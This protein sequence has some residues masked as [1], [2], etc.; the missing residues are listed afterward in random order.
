MSHIHVL[1]TAYIINQL[2]SLLSNYQLL[3]T[4]Y[5]KASSFMVKKTLLHSL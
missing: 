4:S 1:F 5:T 2:K 3:L